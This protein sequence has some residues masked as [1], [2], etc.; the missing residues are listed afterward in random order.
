[1]ELNN[2]KAFISV[3]DCA[4]FSIA[5][6]R[7]YLTQPAV[8]KRIAA[9]ESALDTTLFDRIGRKI[10]L[11]ESGEVLLPVARSICG[12]LNRIQQTIASLGETV[13]GKLSI[14]TSHH[15]GLHRLPTL[16]REFTA[17]YP[18]VEMDLHFMDSEDA[19]A[20]VEANSLEL[21]IITL[22]ENPYP[23]VHTELIWKDP[24][25]IA[26]D[27]QHPLTR[28]KNPKPADLADYPAI[29]PSLD[30]VTRQVLDKALLPFG[31]KPRVAMET[32][33]I[34]T[35]KM[36]VS[37]GLGWG[38]IPKTMVSED[39]ATIPIKGLKLERK[40]GLATHRQR[41]LSV[42]AQAFIELLQ[43]SAD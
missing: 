25:L 28:K 35:I 23:R 34:E 6:E 21:A 40:L 14:G 11:T 24:L 2:L 31:I 29:V 30:T 17:R 9:L 36:M 38:A 19:C 33:Y 20:A 15:I 42:A 27:L 37:V 5:A 7:L 4:S 3:A 10:H 39:L 32:N 16:L 12:D 41:S 1:M 13:A 18:Q 26:T 43:K 22:P 8:S